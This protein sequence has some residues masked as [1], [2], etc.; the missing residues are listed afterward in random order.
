MAFHKAGCA[1]SAVYPASGHPLSKTS[2]IQQRFPYGAVDPPASVKV[3]IEK[4]D[5]D[6]VLPCDDRAVG[7]LHELYGRATGP[8][9]SASKL[10][11][12]I[13]R[14][15][16]PPESY[17]VVSSRYHLLKI[18]GDEGI[19]IPETKLV[20]S[21][22]ELKG[23]G[24]G[25]NLPWVLKA[26]GSWGGHGVKIARHPREAEQCYLELS[27][28]LSAARL[29][30]RMIVNRDPYWLQA[31]RRQTQ[32]AVVVQ[33]HIEGRPA[34]CAVACWKGEVLAG[35]AVEVAN[36]QGATGSATIVRVVDSPEMLLAAQR[37]ARRL[38]LSGLVGLDF[39]IEERTGNLY[40]I[41]MNPR[42][43]PLSH[44]PLGPGR[45]LIAALSAQLSGG[46]LRESPPVT[47]NDTI[48]YFP[49]ACHWD[50]KSQLLQSSYHDVPWEE[51][52][53]VQEL[54]RVPRPDRS[55]LARMLNVLRRKKFEHRSTTRRRFCGC[56][57]E[58][59]IGGGSCP[60]T[61]NGNHPG[62]WVPSPPAS[63]PS[64]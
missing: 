61:L 25:L 27:R 13:E 52:E 33:S 11:A 59:Q 1:V 47:E 38:K 57:N 62:G 22:L 56:T 36:A 26:D 43:T 2:V 3:A 16:G 6:L 42:C 40:L 39:M 54:L 64:F 51:P 14:S 20:S 60:G 37:L 19:R 45:D 7:H 24:A 18:A 4:A 31:W 53:L 23:G 8:S 15:L 50:P 44:L 12:L 5:P 48:A 29:V 21:A 41:E 32:P 9:A 63:P 30:K 46:T 58:P 28:P 34:N 49:Q 35:I 10:R 17:F 55:V